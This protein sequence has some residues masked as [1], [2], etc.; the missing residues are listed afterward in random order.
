MVLE[1]LEALLQ[2]RDLV[3]VVHHRHRGEARPLGRGGDVDEPVE[4][5]AGPDPGVVEVR[6]MEVQ[7]NRRAHGAARYSGGIESPSSVMAPTATISGVISTGSRAAP[8]AAR[9]AKA[10]ACSRRPVSVAARSRS[11]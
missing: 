6:K 5:L 1:A 10:A 11:A 4:E 8:A 3:V 2:R 7:L 9:R